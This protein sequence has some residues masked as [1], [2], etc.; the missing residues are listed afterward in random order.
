MSISKK[1]VRP[2][3]FGI[4]DTIKGGN[5]QLDRRGVSGNPRKANAKDGRQYADLRVKLYIEEIK[6]HIE[7]FR[8]EE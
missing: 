7:T 4:G 1:H 5:A 6:N 3:L 2:N 8:Q